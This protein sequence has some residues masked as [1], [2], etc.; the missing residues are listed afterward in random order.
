MP[1]LTAGTRTTSGEQKA[2]PGACGSAAPK[3]DVAR[4]RRRAG[5]CGA[6]VRGYLSADQLPLL[7][8]WLDLRVKRGVGVLD[9]PAVPERQ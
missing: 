5:V 2:G 7:G 9:E 3:E 4:R 6:R 8:A 1:D